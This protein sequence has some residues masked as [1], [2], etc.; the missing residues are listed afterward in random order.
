M[1]QT[2]LIMGVSGLVLNQWERDFIRDVQPWGFIIFDR[3]IRDAVQL[4]ALTAE[5]REVVGANAPILIDQEGGRVQRLRPPLAVEHLPPLDLMRGLPLELQANAMALRYRYIAHELHG[6]GIDVNCAPMLDVAGP[7]THPF[8]LNRCYGDDPAQVARIGQAVADA[9]LAGG[10]LPI[11]KH[12]PGHGRGTV[13]SHLDLPVVTASAAQL[14]R[15]F[16]PF[17][18]LSGIGMAMTA[19]VVYTAL[20]AHAC[21]TL[22]PIVVRHIR[23]AIGFD[24]LLM[25]DDLSMHAL[26]GSFAGRVQGSLDAGCDMIL[27][28]NGDPD[29]MMQIAA[30]TPRLSGQAAQRAAAALA[31]RRVPEV[32]DAQAG[33]A[34]LTA[35]QTQARDG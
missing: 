4:R 26:G 1:T 25:T 12:I 5:L 8:L 15:D 35:L 2:A 9:H 30:A 31:Q 11:A 20:D 10:V 6:L 22:S 19:H 32:F 29:E 27:H 14:E 18:A 17:A 24:G 33:L 7:E 34:A 16:A 3:N 21:A 13:D 23:D 28:C